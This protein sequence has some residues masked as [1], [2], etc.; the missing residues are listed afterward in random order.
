MKQK[1]GGL[2]TREAER[3]ESV[4]NADCP[5]RLPVLSWTVNEIHENRDHPFKWDCWMAQTLLESG[6]GDSVRQAI[7]TSR[8]AQ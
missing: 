1:V 4:W 5:G 2:L 6:V 3:A 8:G 7:K